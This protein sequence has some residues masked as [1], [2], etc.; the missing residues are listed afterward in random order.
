ME[1]DE[2]AALA[3]HLATEEARGINGQA[4]NID[5]GSVVY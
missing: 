4:I 5:G 3:V 1:A 2:V